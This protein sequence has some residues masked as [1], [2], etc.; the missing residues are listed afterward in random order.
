MADKKEYTFEGALA[1]LEEIVRL[2]DG[3]KT[4]LDESLTLY[5]EGVALVRLCCDRLDAAEQKVK[6]LKP[7]GAGGAVETDFTAAA[8][9]GNSK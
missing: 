9:D 4:P 1:R 7:D 2:L 3:G 6:L 5:E 8:G